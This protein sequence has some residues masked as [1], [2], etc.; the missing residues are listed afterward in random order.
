[1]SSIRISLS[2]AK[3]QQEVSTGGEGYDGVAL[4]I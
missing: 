1:M 4:D 2:H 3:D